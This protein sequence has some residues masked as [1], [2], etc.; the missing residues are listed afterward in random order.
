MGTVL[1]LSRPVAEVIGDL[2]DGTLGRLHH[3][4][5]PLD[6]EGKPSLWPDGITDGES[7]GWFE[8]PNMLHFWGGQ[9]YG[10]LVSKLRRYGVRVIHSF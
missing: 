4:H 2:K 5:K 1:V 7:T 10:P 3:V 9:N 6:R 8:A